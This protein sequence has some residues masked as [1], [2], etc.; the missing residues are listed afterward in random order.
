MSVRK[1]GV[2]PPGAGRRGG[3]CCRCGQ[4]RRPSPAPGA[5][6]SG[7]ACDGRRSAEAVRDGDVRRQPLRSRPWGLGAFPP[8]LPQRPLAHPPSCGRSRRCPPPAAPSS[9]T[10][11]PFPSARATL[12][13]RFPGRRHLPG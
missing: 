2:R 9:S 3:E 13:A 11:P 8:R 10:P 6:P 1:A 7:V 4:G 5:G 12:P